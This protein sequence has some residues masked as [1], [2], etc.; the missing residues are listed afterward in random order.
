MDPP[1]LPETRSYD[2]GRYYRHEMTV[3]D[4]E[5]LLKALLEL[6]GMVV[7]SGYDSDLYNRALTGWQSI[8]LKTSGSSRFGSAS[9]TECLW[10][11]PAAQARAPQTS[12]FGDTA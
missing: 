1:Y 11:N 8:R 7:L 6:E 3:F 4:H 5:Q 9:R 2:G 10:L 12:L